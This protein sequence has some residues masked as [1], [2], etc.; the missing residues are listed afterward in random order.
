[1]DVETKGVQ[2][3]RGKTSYHVSFNVEGQVLCIHGVAI[4]GKTP[5]YK[6]GSRRVA[7][8]GGGWHACTGTPIPKQLQPIADEALKLKAD[9][10]G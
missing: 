1:M 4:V 6:G 5:R 7:W 9:R 10:D 2:V 3:V 8:S